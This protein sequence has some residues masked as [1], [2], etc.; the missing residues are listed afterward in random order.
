[1]TIIRLL[2]SSGKQVFNIFYYIFAHQ[3]Q[4]VMSGDKVYLLQSAQIT[5]I[6]I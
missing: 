5:E 4:L 1:M 2:D 3:G 6:V